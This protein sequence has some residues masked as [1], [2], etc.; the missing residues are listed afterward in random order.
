L[1][2][3]V[4]TYR[5]CNACI[6]TRQL[7]RGMQCNCGVSVSELQVIVHD[8]HGLLQCKWKDAMIAWKYS[9]CTQLDSF[10]VENSLWRWR[11]WF[12][13]PHCV[14]GFKQWISPVVQ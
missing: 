11:H 7:T 3:I 14:Q 4:K 13:S 5:F 2:F 12:A 8:S 9:S 1:K 6:G 10:S